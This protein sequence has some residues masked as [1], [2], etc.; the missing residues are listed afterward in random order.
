MPKKFHTRKERL[1]LQHPLGKLLPPLTRDEFNALV[2]DIEVH[3]QHDLIMKFGGKVLEGW[4]RYRACLR[5]KL[6]PRFDEFKGD[7]NDALAFVF[8]KNICRRHLKAKDKKK[9]TDALIKAMPEK[10]DRELG[11]M[12]KTDH[13]VIGR[14]RK[15]LESTGAAPQLPKRIGGDGKARQQPRRP[16]PAL[17]APTPGK[18]AEQSKVEPP[19][20]PPIKQPIEQKPE[21]Q[22]SLAPPGGTAPPAPPAS[23]IEPGDTTAIAPPTPA[24]PP[25]EPEVEPEKIGEVGL[26]VDEW[27]NPIS[28]AWVMGTEEQRD[29]FALRFHKD[30]SKRAPSDPIWSGIGRPVQTAPA[31]A[32]EPAAPETAPTESPRRRKGSKPGPLTP[33]QMRANEAEGQQRLPL[34]E[35]AD[36][37]LENDDGLDIPPFL[38]RT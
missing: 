20:E 34:P 22:V 38:R 9:A 19:I 18:S 10:S 15:R 24:E 2:A 27:R 3:G 23:P 30:V 5:L 13:K 12:T 8:S 29:E 28:F 36:T 6:R 1:L 31:S 26:K 32:G 21:Q 17:A 7:T 4:H 33:E 25:V 11:R 35:A 37:K 16:E 14:A